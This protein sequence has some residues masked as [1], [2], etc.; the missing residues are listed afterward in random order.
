MFCLFQSISL[1][2]V[3]FSLSFKTIR[4]SF[5]DKYSHQDVT[6]VYN[7]LRRSQPGW[8]AESAQLLGHIHLSSLPD[9]SDGQLHVNGKKKVT[10][11]VNAFYLHSQSQQKDG[12]N[13]N[14]KC[15]V[16]SFWKNTSAGRRLIRIVLYSLISRMYILETFLRNFVYQ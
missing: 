13:N 14:V 6:Y 8:A 16:T 3:Y 10:Y 1:C 9:G 4:F 5:E 15:H 12:P 2:S 11:Q 7:V